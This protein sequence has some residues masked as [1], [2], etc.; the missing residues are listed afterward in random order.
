MVKKT[1]KKELTKN[2][3][4]SVWTFFTLLFP[5][6]LLCIIVT[7]PKSIEFSL[8]GLSLF[9]YQAVLLKNF[10]EKYYEPL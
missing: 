2:E 9:F 3:K 8:I 7:F 4:K 6:L 1:P 10:V 5:S